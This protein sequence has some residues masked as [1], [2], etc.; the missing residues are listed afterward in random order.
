MTPI[1]VFDCGFM[2]QEIADTFP[3]SN[4][5]RQGNGQTGATSC[6]REGSHSIFHL[7]SCRFH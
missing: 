5:P 2:T 4:L 3:N 6:E 7:I 1:V